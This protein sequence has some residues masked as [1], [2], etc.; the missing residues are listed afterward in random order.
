MDPL[1]VTA[2]IVAVV[3]AASSVGRTLGKLALL[4]GAPNTIRALNNEIEDLRLLLQEIDTLL[5]RDI[6]SS[7]PPLHQSLS[8]S[9]QRAKEK[10]LELE[11]I[12]EYQ[13]MIVGDHGNA[14]VNR[15]AWARQQTTVQRIQGDLRSIRL[16]L[17]AA[18]G[19]LNASTS[20]RIVTRLERIQFVMDDTSRIQRQEASQSL[21][22]HQRAIEGTL[23]QLLETHLGRHRI[24]ADESN[25]ALARPSNEPNVAT[26]GINELPHSL[27]SAGGFRLRIRN[28]VSMIVG[29]YAIAVSA[30]EA[31]QYLIDCSELYFL[32]T[33]AFPS[34]A[35]DATLV[36]NEDSENSNKAPTKSWPG[37][38]SSSDK[39][40]LF[41]VDTLRFVKFYCMPELIRM[42]KAFP[43]TSRKLQL[44]FS[45][46]ETLEGFQFTL[47]H[48][49]VLGILPLNLSIALQGMSRSLINEC[50]SGGRSAIYWA[51]RRGDAKCLKILLEH[52]AD[53]GIST[54]KGHSPLHTAAYSGNYSCCRLLLDAHAE[55]DCRG[56]CQATPLI[57]A[58]QQ[59]DAM[60]IAKLFIDHGADINA[61]NCT[62]ATAILQASFN[63]RFQL[64]EYLVEQGADLHVAENT[65]DTVVHNAVMGNESRIVRLLLQ[66]GAPY[67]STSSE[68]G[69]I[70]Q[71]A[72]L[73][74]DTPVLEEL[75]RADL[76]GIEIEEKL[77][78][79]TAL[80]LAK[81][82]KGVCDEWL[83]AFEALL[84]SIK[85][86]CEGPDVTTLHE[87]NSGENGNQ[88]SQDNRGA[89]GTSGDQ[90]DQDEDGNEIFVDTV[91]YHHG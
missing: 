85:R 41:K 59:I 8:G 10:L 1:S 50:D 67:H 75:T 4:R 90:G 88:G 22:H 87:E 26:S 70:L 28:P 31:L 19:L 72:A 29:A 38:A 73:Y 82:R 16:D 56:L 6:D 30:G 58:S 68:T 7:G 62:G 83:P 11:G 89:G 35:Q 18:L 14:T 52:G 37:A 40:M 45:D 57:T 47:L 42:K 71:A 78:G 15:F 17:V 61:R 76:I 44:M 64:A 86:D 48:K 9:L 65:G 43:E 79:S 53:P 80:E 60:D 55:V 74:S 32:A 2:G 13:I 46:T 84:R 69:T 24:L 51:A 66:R 49:I 23:D 81:R 54:K 20:Y 27:L 39:T 25:N 3:G 34:W 36:F 77:R 91:E 33:L 21:A 63:G 5:R 12:L